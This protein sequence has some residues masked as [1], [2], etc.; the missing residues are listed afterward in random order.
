MTERQKRRE[1]R[2]KTMQVKKIFLHSEENSSF[3]T[4]L[5]PLES[6]ELLAKISRELWFLETGKLAPNRLD[7]S[8][9]R[10]F[11]RES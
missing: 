6:W 5:S 11:T 2:L 9:I 10:I 1:Q 8:Q 4:N 3:C 7:K